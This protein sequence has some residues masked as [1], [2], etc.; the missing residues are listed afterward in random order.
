MLRI[1]IDSITDKG[2]D[3]DERVDASRLPLLNAVSQEDALR[4]NRPV[5]VRVHATVAGET[6][7]IDGSATSRVHIHC[8]RCLAQFDMPI[9][10]YF[11]AAAVV[12]LPTPP[13]TE[14]EDETELSADDMGLIAYTG[15]SIDLRKEIAQQ[16]IMALPF[17][18]LCSKACKGLCSHCGV[19]LN[20]TP[21]RCA[22]EE[23]GNPFA[24]L[25]TF[26][27]PERQE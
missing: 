16:V 18:P 1:H 2:L 21:C 23:K 20:Q 26:S 3:L 4:F 15:N 6:V 7:L 19:N 14:T 24:A 5:H 25:K 22:N 27:F 8:S 10:S 11:S 9:E 13:Q 12:E 17:N